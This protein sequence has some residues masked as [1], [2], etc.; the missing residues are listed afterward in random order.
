MIKTIYIG[1]TLPPKINTKIEQ[2][3]EEI[4]FKYNIKSKRNLF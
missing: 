2:I 1:I 3:G 4:D